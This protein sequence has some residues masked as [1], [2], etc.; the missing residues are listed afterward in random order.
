MNKWIEESI[1]KSFNEAIEFRRTMHRNPELSGQ[2]YQTQ[3][4][5]I[6]KL[7]EYGIKNFKCADTGV[8]A[9]IENGD[10]KI[11]ASRAD[12]DA[13]PIIEESNVDF[14]S[15]NHGV[16][17]A[18]GHDVHTTVQLMVAKILNENKDKWKGSIKFFFQPAEE[19]TGGAIRM[20]ESGIDYK[21]YAMFAF[22]VAP[23]IAVGKIG[24][25]YGTIHA[26]AVL[27]NFKIKGTSSHAALPHLGV[28]SIYVG[29]QVVNYLQS[30]VSRVTDPRD[31]LVITIGTFNAGTAT[32]I[33]A[34]EAILT[35]TMRFLDEDVKEQTKNYILKNLPLFVKSFNADIEITLTD[36]YKT[37]VNDDNKTKF[38]ENISKNVLGNNNVEVIKKSRMDAED[39]GYF[40]DKIPGS[41]YRLG[42][43][44]EKIDAIYDLHHPK[45]KVDENAIKIGIK[46]QLNAI[47]EFL[48]EN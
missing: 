36:S 32:N 11:A 1:E 35:G 18:C 16:M 5:I 46:V 4:R 33:L 23:E 13:L 17:H 6:K 44:N 21:A 14:S 42:I 41:Y 26:S 20:L 48:N 31:N 2:E 45:F 43:R 19:T 25:K 7:N 30:I 10:G 28:D 15:L 22:H 38:L 40:L 8:F 24:I 12:I 39:V 3:E 37:V 29:A 47:V 9:I 27:F 34:N